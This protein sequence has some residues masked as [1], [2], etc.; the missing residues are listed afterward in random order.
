[1]D[2]VRRRVESGYL[3]LTCAAWGLVDRSVRKSQA[4]FERG[5]CG[6]SANADTNAAVNI[7]RAGTRPAP[8]GRNAAQKIRESRVAA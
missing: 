2:V 7:L 5:S 8:R 6:H 1:M 3:S 4:A